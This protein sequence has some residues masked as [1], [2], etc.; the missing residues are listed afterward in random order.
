MPSK[1][2]YFFNLLLAVF[3]A[4]VEDFFEDE[5]EDFLQQEDLLHLFNCFKASFQK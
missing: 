2:A 3:L 4:E 5:V 1:K